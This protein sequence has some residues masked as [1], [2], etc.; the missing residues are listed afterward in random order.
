MSITTSI[1]KIM[2]KIFLLFSF[3]FVLVLFAQTS[4]LSTNE[5]YTYTKNCLNED[6]SKK[7]EAVNY[8]DGLGR[9]KQTI[10]IKASPAGKDIV[11]PIE[12]NAFGI[13]ERSYLSIPQVVTQNGAIYDNPKTNASQTYGSDIYFYSESV[14]ESS[15]IGKLLSSKKPGA[16]YQS[17]SIT[18]AYETNAASDV[19]LY[20]VQTTWESGAT[21]NEISTTTHYAAGQL[22]KNSVTDEDGNSTTEFINGKGQKIL[23]RKNDGTQNSDTYYVYNKFNQLAYVIPPL[24]INESLSQITLNNLCYQYKYDSKSRLVEKK[25]PGKGWEYLV[26]DKADRLIFT[27]DALMHP[28]DKWLFT[29]YDQFDRV[30]YTGIVRGEGSRQ[31]LQNMIS[32]LVITENK[33]TGSF[34]K[35]GMEIYYSNNYFPYLETILSVNYYDTY[36]SNA[37]SRP[38]TILG[39]S[40]ITDNLG[41]TINTKDLITASY[42]KNIE[43]DNWTKNYIW[44]DDEAR[45]IGS[46][47]INYL[48]GYTKT[49]TELD[50]TGMP[51]KTNTYHLRKQGENGV[52][53]KERFVYDNQNRLKQHFHQVDVNAEEL[54]TEN[55]YNELS[56]LANKK[57]GNNLQS[58]DYA[59]NIRGWMTD[60][61]RDQMLLSDL[62]GKLFS[63]KIKY[64]QKEGITNP[65][66]SLFSGKDVKD[67]YNGSI[68]EVDWRAVDNKGNYPSLTPKRYGYA[69]DGL[70]RL[71]AGYYQNPMNPNSKENTESLTYDL[72]GNITNLYRTSVIESG[73]NTATVID[74]LEYIYE[75]TNKSNKLTNI[76]DHT[77][78]YTG[79]EG[80]GNKIGYDLNG[81]MTNMPDK[82]IS[83]IS[84]NYLNLPKKIQYGGINIDYSYNAGGIKFQ[85]KTPRTE[86]GIIDCITYIDTTDYLDGFQYFSS[87]NSGSGG[88]SSETFAFSTESARAMEQQ[89]FTP[90]NINITTDNQTLK[91]N[92]KNQDLQFF[93][94]SE[95][96]Y[97]YK[98]NQYIYQYKD[99]LGNVRVSFAR[100]SAGALEITDNNDYYPFGMNHL[101]SGNAFFGQNSYKS[102][103]YNGKELQ[104]TGMYDYG[105]RMYMA[106]IGRWGVVDP[107]AETTRRFSTYNYALNNPISFIDPD[108]RKAITPAEGLQINSSSDSAWWGSFKKHSASSSWSPDTEAW[109]GG[110]GSSATFGQTPAYAAAMNAWQNGQSF[111]LTNNNGYLYWNTL[112]PANANGMLDD[113]S[114]G[115]VTR[116]SMKLTHQT[117]SSD[118]NWAKAAL[119]FMALDISVPDPSDA[120][121]PK[122]AAYGVVGAVAGTYL[123]LKMEKEIDRIERRNLKPQ[124]FLYQL[125]ATR[126]GLYPNVRGGTTFLNTGDVWKY[127]ETTTNNR[128]S[129]NKLRAQGLVMNPIFYGNQTTIK[130]QEKIMIYGYFVVNGSLP[131][132]NKIFR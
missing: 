92:A 13:Q 72:N 110:G 50:F 89:A 46:H 38:A 24:A 9:A 73:T 54:L 100:N 30:I 70:N 8:S 28:S 3:L 111:S 75:S 85:K 99:H 45:A 117:P 67:K 131:P 44:Y 114:I 60:I 5:N 62:G 129:D 58:I 41:N 47:S 1:K 10:A 12:Y 126:P 127:G 91:T 122:W 68:V 97:D 22:I 76:N 115:G 66:P 94:T 53:T 65:D 23:V 78:N 21:K 95:G 105:A 125:E 19:K 87:V 31:A 55:T 6:C 88:G 82:N 17:H 108:G 90:N 61:N 128:Y 106:D 59:Y 93:P 49:E 32:N 16:D 63:Y 15:P 25:L 109:T 124:G 69:Y 34:T 86:C 96:F 77:N 84:Y 83:E 74:N 79:Y 103:K 26:Y 113:G 132:G 120:A 2:K 107:L 102:H 123:Y 81:N 104:E 4:S 56:Q 18:Y 11:I 98:N 130:I 14:I 116:H 39:K 29:K 33:V 101:K 7:I 71:T 35:N 36:P 121:W 43:D 57:V 42:V 48:G 52:T 80:G 118:D 51:Q 112:D 119:G 20:T 27:Q 40:T 64:N 37:P